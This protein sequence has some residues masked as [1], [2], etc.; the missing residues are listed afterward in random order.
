MSLI[1]EALDKAVEQDDEGKS[2]KEHYEELNEKTT[3]QTPSEETAQKQSSDQTQSSTENFQI[4]T[5]Y[6]LLLTAMIVLTV[7]VLGQIVFL[8][9]YF[10]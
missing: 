2:A 8:F 9:F 5:K 1:K 10:S 4:P 6:V 7:V 3:E